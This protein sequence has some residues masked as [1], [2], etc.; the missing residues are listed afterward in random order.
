MYF[1]VCSPEGSTSR[2]FFKV[3]VS[4]ENTIDFLRWMPGGL[5][6]SY[7]GQNIIDFKR[8][9]IATDVK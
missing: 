6:L 5:G 1:L 3:W 7:Y 4:D 9:L 2:F 8:A